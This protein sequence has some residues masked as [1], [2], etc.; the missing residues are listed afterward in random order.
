MIEYLARGARKRM[1]STSNM[2][3]REGKD[4]GE[5]HWNGATEAD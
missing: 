2:G 4:S 3:A 5:I 1:Y